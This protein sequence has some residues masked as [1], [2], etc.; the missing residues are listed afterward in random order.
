MPV[1]SADR[2]AA[3]IDHVAPEVRLRPGRTGGAPSATPHRR[4]AFG[5]A[6]P[7]V[8][9]RPRR[10]GGAP[11][12]TPYRWCAFG[13]V[14][15]EVRLRPRRTGGAPSAT[16]YRRCAFGQVA[17]EV[18]LGRN[19]RDVPIRQ[20]TRTVDAI[21]AQLGAFGIVVAEGIHNVDHL[22]DAGRDVP[23]AARPA[24][25]MLAGQRRDRQALIE[26]VTVRIAAMRS[27]DALVRRPATVRG[28]GAISSR[29]FAASTGCAVLRRRLRPSRVLEFFQRQPACLIGMEACAGAHYRA[30]EL[31]TSG[32]DVRL[33]QPSCMKGYVNRGKTDKADAEAICAAVSRWSM[34][35]VPVK[36]EETRAVLMDDKAREF[37]VRQQTEIANWSC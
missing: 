17:L 13:H 31:I 6:V 12:A 5:H 26:D 9:L 28:A 29:A 8:R 10:T 11:S 30:H 20:R 19:V 33:M 1:K 3:L 2:Q 35:F 25:D 34:R 16:P 15:P 7:V 21:R 18:R 22:V 4:C 27:E 32:H 14:V 23:G 36:S 24:L 37:L